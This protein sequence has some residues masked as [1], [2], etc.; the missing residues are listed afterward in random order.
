MAP[1]QKCA[2]ER[3]KE[4]ERLE[5]VDGIRKQRAR[6]SGVEQAG[7]GS[8]VAGC[9]TRPPNQGSL[10][11]CLHLGFVKSVPEVML[12][13]L[14]HLRVTE[15]RTQ[16]RRA[17]RLAPPLAPPYFLKVKRQKAIYCELRRSNGNLQQHLKHVCT[18]APRP[19]GRER[20]RR[21]RACSL[22]SAT[23][24]QQPGVAGGF[25][26]ESPQS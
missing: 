26:T 19:G 2:S 9:R 5:C 16:S 8:Q 24:A 17:P 14:H 25:S 4:Q 6:P 11:C 3:E 18:M 21:S 23:T 10:S 7:R 1:F 13:H 15:D 22:S 20:Q 12:P